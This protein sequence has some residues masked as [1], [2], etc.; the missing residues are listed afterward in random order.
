MGVW[1]HNFHS[2]QPAYVPSSLHS[3]PSI[4]TVLNNYSTFFYPSPSI[5]LCQTALKKSILSITRLRTADHKAILV[6]RE[7]YLK[8]ADARVS[9]AVL[10]W[11]RWIAQF[12]TWT[13][14]NLY[15]WDYAFFKELIQFYPEA[16]HEVKIN[17]E[18][19]EK[20]NNLGVTMQ[21]FLLKDMLRWVHTFRYIVL[22]SKYHKMNSYLHIFLTIY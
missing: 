10:H 3:L 19:Y 18:M 2:I 5:S 20:T 16:S 21:S 7:C 12:T 14:S 4:P 15:F 17:L 22:L 1:L 8:L 13:Q 6:L 9:P 11:V